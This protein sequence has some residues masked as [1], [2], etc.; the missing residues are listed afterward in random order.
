MRL[1]N[2][3]RAS[4]SSNLISFISLLFL[5]LQHCIITTSYSCN[6]AFLESKKRKLLNIW[7]RNIY[8]LYIVISCADTWHL[9]A[10]VYHCL[11]YTSAVSDIDLMPCGFGGLMHEMP[12]AWMRTRSLTWSD[13]S[14][15]SQIDDLSA[16]ESASWT[17]IMI[18]LNFFKPHRLIVI[19]AIILSRTDDFPIIVTALE[20]FFD[21]LKHLGAINTITRP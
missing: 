18:Q 12:R 8:L 19:I 21:K 16:G 17:I 10:F 5:L 6:I 15:V 1:G 9:N 11:P 7:K 20:S 3:Q 2:N 4:S 14:T 13:R